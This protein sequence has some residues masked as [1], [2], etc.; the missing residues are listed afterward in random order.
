MVF[1]AGFPGQPGTQGPP[2]PD[3]PPGPK[4]K[5]KSFLSLLSFPISF[6]LCLHIGSSFCPCASNSEKALIYFNLIYVSFHR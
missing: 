5:F 3:G 4:G 1:I 6:F 2:G